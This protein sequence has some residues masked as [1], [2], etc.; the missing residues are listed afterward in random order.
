MGSLW[1]ADTYFVHK[2]LAEY[3]EE[4]LTKTGEKFILA[5]NRL[6]CAIALGKRGEPTYKRSRKSLEDILLIL[7]N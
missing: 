7:N 6:I 1:I 3:I 5:D 2:E 4:E